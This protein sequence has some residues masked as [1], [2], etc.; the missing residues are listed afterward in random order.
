MTKLLL[1][2]ILVGIASPYWGH[3]FIAEG[4]GKIYAL[5]S[6]V[7]EDEKFILNNKS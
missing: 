7:L 6:L 2:S 4:N 1:M 5:R 3:T